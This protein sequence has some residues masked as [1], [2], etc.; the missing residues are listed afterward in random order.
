MHTPHM[1][2]CTH[3]TCTHAYTHAHTIH[4]CKDTSLP[5]QFRMLPSWKAGNLLPRTCW[6]SFKTSTLPKGEPI[7]SPTNT[8]VQVTL[9]ALSMHIEGSM[10]RLLPAVRV[11]IEGS[12]LRILPAVRV[13]IEGATL[14][15]LPAVRVHIEGST[16][17]TLHIR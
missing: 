14:R 6:Q 11:H 7:A 9:R 3:H 16:L 8:Q 15:L 17:R 13:H 4:T 1:H 10:L 2:T 5:L 12:T